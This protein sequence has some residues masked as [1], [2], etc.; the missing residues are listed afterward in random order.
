MWKLLTKCFLRFFFYQFYWIG[1]K[2]KVWERV[3]CRSPVPIQYLHQ[4][5]ILLVSHFCGVK[6]PSCFRCRTMQY[7]MQYKFYQNSAYTES[8]M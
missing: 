2:A 1:N 8:A 4:K 5:T 7:V 3:D 6:G